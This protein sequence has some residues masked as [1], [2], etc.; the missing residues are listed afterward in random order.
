MTDPLH[1]RTRATPRR[2]HAPL[3]AQCAAVSI[4]FAVLSIAPP[5]S[6]AMLLLP[7]AATGGD[8]ANLAL[9]RG[10]RLLGAG[11]I[12]GSIVVTGR[13]D[14]LAGAMLRQGTLTVATVPLLCGT[15]VRDAAGS[16]S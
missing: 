7:V 1:R 8:V 14:A 2:W 9:A 3:I 5:A 11:P 13:R 6:G 16:R 10:A 4:G 15:L 12:R